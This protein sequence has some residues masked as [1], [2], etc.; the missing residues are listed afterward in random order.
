LR[1]VLLVA[2]IGC[3]TLAAWRAQWE[4]RVVVGFHTYII[5]LQRPAVWS[6]PEA[7]SYG[8]F[9]QSFEDLPSTELPAHVILK[10]D[11]TLLN[12]L[13]YVW[14]I[15]VLFGA[16]YVAWRGPRRD[17]VFHCVLGVAIG[18]TSGAGICFGLWILAGG[19]GPPVPEW[20]GLAG[21]STGLFGAL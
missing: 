17:I 10:W 15:T 2:I 6:P 3:L 9:R 1:L 21:L 8:H 19:W 14:G 11:W 12:L 18:M 13:M 4:S 7:P 20:F 16:A 5:S